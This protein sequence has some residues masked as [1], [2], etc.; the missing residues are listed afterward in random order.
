MMLPEKFLALLKK[1]A[2]IKKNVEQPP[3]N[4]EQGK[5]LIIKQN[6]L[7]HLANKLHDIQPFCLSVI[8]RKKKK[9]A[10]IKA[11]HTNNIHSRK[12]FLQLL[13]FKVC[14]SLLLRQNKK[15]C[16]YCGLYA[17]SLHF[18]RKE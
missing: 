14:L 7:K 4:K 17:S 3:N 10:F 5:N 9:K 12:Y 8:K 11:S 1:D 16:L 2:F 6:N 18:L 15:L 13:N